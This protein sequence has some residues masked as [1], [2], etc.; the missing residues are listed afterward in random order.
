[1][2]EPWQPL[3]GVRV[4]DFSMFVPGPFCSAILADLGAEVIKIEPLA[5]DPGRRYVPVQF[6]TE[7]RTKRSICL[8][9]KSERSGEIVFRLARRSDLA[10][11]GFRPGVAKRLGIDFESLR[12]ANPQLIHCSISGYGQTGP[13]R[14]R[15]GHDVNYVAAAGALSFPG[16]WLA[17]PVR[18]SIAIADMGGGSAAAIAVLAA[19]AGRARTGPGGRRGPSLVEAAV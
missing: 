17:P 19:L 13:W 6:R 12:Q 3:A 8:D 1:M 14:E 10:I 15:P 2:A 9:L 4:V 11:E 18:S 5:G 16:Q 7:N